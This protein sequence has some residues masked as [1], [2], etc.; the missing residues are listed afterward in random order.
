MN[1]DL[2]VAMMEIARRR[3]SPLDYLQSLRK[4]I[5]SAVFA[6]DDPLPGI[7]EMPMLIQLF[8]KRIIG[9]SRNT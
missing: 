4:P 3:L 2:P 6:T 1:T 9:R 8:C 7:L 5:E